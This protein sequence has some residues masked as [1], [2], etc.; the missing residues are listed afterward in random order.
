MEKKGNAFQHAF[1]NWTL[2]DR[3][4]VQ[5]AKTLTDA[6]EDWRGND[7]GNKSM[8]LNWSLHHD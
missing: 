5:K 7:C 6:H 2:A 4:D 8:D 3:T 1:W